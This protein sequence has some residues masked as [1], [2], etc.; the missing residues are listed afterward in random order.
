MH[1]KESL[2]DRVK[3]TQNNTQKMEG[4]S[5]QT[6]FYVFIIIYRATDQIL[7]MPAKPSGPVIALAPG[8]S[9]SLTLDPS[10]FAHS[11]H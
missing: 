7:R 4:D 3:Q 5:S 8:L 9:W 11:Q 1:D 6:P 10:T 2:D